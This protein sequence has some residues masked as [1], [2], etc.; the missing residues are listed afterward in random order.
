MNAQ[1]NTRNTH[2]STDSRIK[3]KKVQTNTLVE[4]FAGMFIKY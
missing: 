4:P 1:V 3:T 2:S